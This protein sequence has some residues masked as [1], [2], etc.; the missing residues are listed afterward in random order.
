VPRWL[1]LSPDAFEAARR[2]L[3]SGEAPLPLPE[4]RGGANRLSQK[5]LLDLALARFQLGDVRFAVNTSKQI[6]AEDPA[7]WDARAAQTA[8]LWE[9][10]RRPY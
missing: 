8:F 6:L 7:Y 10:V 2:L 4:P 1:L 5:N 9:Q 3:L